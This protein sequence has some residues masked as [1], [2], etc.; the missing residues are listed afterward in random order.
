MFAVDEVVDIL[1]RAYHA[2]QRIAHRLDPEHAFRGENILWRAVI[3]G[4]GA[5]GAILVLW[6]LFRGGRIGLPKWLAF[7]GIVTVA[8]YVLLRLMPRI[9]DLARGPV[10]WGILTLAWCLLVGGAVF[11]LDRRRDDPD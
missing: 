11:E 2:A 1:G 3:L 10:G 7:A 6:F 4:L 8:V 9:G 5:V